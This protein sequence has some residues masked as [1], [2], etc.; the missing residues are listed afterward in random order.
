MGVHSD[1]SHLWMVQYPGVVGKVVYT[2]VFP[3]SPFSLGYLFLN[4]PSSLHTLSFL[5]NIPSVVDSHTPG[6]VGTLSVHIGQETHGNTPLA[7]HQG[8][9]SPGNHVSQEGTLLLHNL[10]SHPFH[11]P[12]PSLA[13][14]HHHR[15]LAQHTQ[16]AEHVSPCDDG[17]VSGG[18]DDGVDAH[19]RRYPEPHDTRLGP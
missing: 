10:V 4:I 11:T 13:P 16:L 3:Y 7:A 15:G 2:V 6:P 8:I 18:G 1:E 17:D 12:E 19:G 14:P 9:L 5:L